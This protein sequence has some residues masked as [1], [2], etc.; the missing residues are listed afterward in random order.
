MNKQKYIAVLTEGV[1][2]PEI[3]SALKG[4]GYT[5]KRESDYQGMVTHHYEKAVAPVKAGV[6][7]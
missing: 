3:I 4:C 7:H 6:N 5:L 2:E 1:L